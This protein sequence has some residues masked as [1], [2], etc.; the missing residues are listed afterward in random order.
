LGHA[1]SFWAW[2]LANYAMPKQDAPKGFYE[3]Y[4]ESREKKR[5]KVAEQRMDENIEAGGQRGK[6]LQRV[7]KEWGM[8]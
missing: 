4:R 2:A 7:L 1:D 3:Q 6:S 8:K 5:V